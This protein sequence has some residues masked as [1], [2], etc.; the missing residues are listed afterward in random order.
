MKL[1]W[2]EYAS[3]RSRKGTEEYKNFYPVYYNE[4]CSPDKVRIEL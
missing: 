3:A 4:M 1:N 2:N